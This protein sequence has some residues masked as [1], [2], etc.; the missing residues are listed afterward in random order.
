MEDDCS[1]SLKDCVSGSSQVPEVPQ[2]PQ[3]RPHPPPCP[4]PAKRAKTVSTSSSPVNDLAVKFAG[5]SMCFLGFFS[6][7]QNRAPPRY[8]TQMWAVRSD[9]LME[10]SA[11]MQKQPASD[12][13][14]YFMWHA[15][16]NNIAAASTSIAGQTGHWS[17]CNTKGQYL[18]GWEVAPQAIAEL[19]C[20][21]LEADMREKQWLDYMKREPDLFKKC[22][23]RISLS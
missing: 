18:E 15:P 9:Y 13:D 1:I 23:A 6:K 20:V 5:A 2:V 8:G 3:G 11:D 17:D 4:P 7:K 19:T 12:I 14:M 16:G 21:K 22:S 10:L